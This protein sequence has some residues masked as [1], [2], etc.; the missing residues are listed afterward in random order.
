MSAVIVQ[1]PGTGSVVGFSNNGVIG[2]P[3]QLSN[4]NDAGV[5][6][7]IWELVDKPSGSA[8]VLDDVNSATPQFTPDVAGTY[9]INLKTYADAGHTTLDDEDQTATG[10]PLAGIF[11]VSWR[12]P[13]ATETTEANPTRG[14]AGHQMN[15][16]L[17]ET[18]RHLFM[19]HFDSVISAG[20]SPYSPV[21]YETVLVNTTGGA[22]TVNLPAIAAS[23]K[24][25]RITIKDVGRA[26][27]AITVAR[28]GSDTIDGATSMSL[29]GTG[30]EGEYAVLESDGTS[31]WHRIGGFSAVAGGSLTAPA[32]PG[33]DG[34][35][36]IASGG[37]LTYGL[38]NTA[39]IAASAVT[40]AKLAGDVTLAAVIAKGNTTGANPILQ[41]SGS[42]YDSEAGVDTLFKRDGNNRIVFASTSTQFRDPATPANSLIQLANGQVELLNGTTFNVIDSIGLDLALR[43]GASTRFNTSGVNTITRPGANGNVTMA[44]SAGAFKAQYKESD[45][46]FQIASAVPINWPVGEALIQK[47]GFNRFHT[48]GA[49]TLIGAA[50][51]GSV[52]FLINNT[53]YA[54]VF[55]D[56]GGT[57]AYGLN[58]S[59]V[60]GSTAFVGLGIAP[61][62][63][64]GIT[65]HLQ[66]SPAA[67]GDNDGGG[68]WV[69]PGGGT[70]TGSPG[71]AGIAN[72]SAVPIWYWDGSEDVMQ[73]V[74]ETRITRDALTTTQAYGLRLRNTTA[75]TGGTPQQFSPMLAFEG[76]SADDEGLDQQIEA[77]MQLQPAAS[78][79]N[80][81]FQL[82]FLRQVPGGGGWQQFA[83][84]EIGGTLFPRFELVA[85]AGGS[86]TF[87]AAPINSA[88]KAPDSKLQSA[89]NSGA[90]DD[91][92]PGFSDSSGT[93]MLKYDA[94]NDRIVP[95]K[96]I[97]WDTELVSDPATGGG[98]WALY[99]KADGMYVRAPGNGLVSQLAGT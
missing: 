18:A 32:N 37:D 36:A 78:D 59:S 26:A 39:Q 4:Q 1:D 28:A 74:R 40:L 3:V 48:F 83:D 24:G 65:L 73:G 35:V 31:E 99:P 7:W 70:G 9:L 85:G 44:N 82:A 62:S 51:G 57:G 89:I 86:A 19:G 38:V 72:N 10:T 56:T 58:I 33:D 49:S 16:I 17:K 2:S 93:M 20:D 5:S 15:D 55:D 12:I 69:L 47:A 98:E 46:E 91:G 75:G 54:N 71:D 42:A 94:T 79:P 81:K 6:G 14:W 84:F 52:N 21:S 60:V 30:K 13:A 96:V 92:D 88:S 8:A 34:K 23:N 22:V 63:G 76:H 43:V 53:L 67:A 95:S 90:G 25:H 11:N 87:R 41:S 64:D 29:A 66:G 68:A 27:A 97:V 80:A 61:S 45:D 50:D 77:A